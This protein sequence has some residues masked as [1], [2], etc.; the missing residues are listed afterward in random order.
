MNNALLI[1][2]V[3]FF[4]I[5][6][7]ILWFGFGGIAHREAYMDLETWNT[8]VRKDRPIEGRFRWLSVGLLLSEL[9]LCWRYRE[10]T[11][12]IIWAPTPLY[13]WGSW[14]GTFVVLVLLW[15]YLRFKNGASEKYPGI[16]KRTGVKE[17]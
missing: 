3:H 17:E 6:R 8:D 11:G 2:P 13:I 16:N 1:P 5:A 4:P 15:F 10:G 7:L 12:N 14:A 9:I